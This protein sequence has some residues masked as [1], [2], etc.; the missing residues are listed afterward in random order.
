MGTK[1]HNTS[2]NGRL[3]FRIK[4]DTLKIGLRF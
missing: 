1:E 2:S 3:I 4:S